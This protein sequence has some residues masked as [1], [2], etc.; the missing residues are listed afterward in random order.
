MRD[1]GSDAGI[2][3]F[4]STVEDQARRSALL[5]MVEE[6]ELDALRRVAVRK[7]VHQAL[8]SLAARGM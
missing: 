8:S 5:T 2:L 6:E 1:S 3:E 4:L 7:G